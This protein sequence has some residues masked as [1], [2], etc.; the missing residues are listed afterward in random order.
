[1]LVRS[2]SGT[3]VARR[4]EMLGKYIPTESSKQAKDINSSSGEVTH[5]PHD[6]EASPVTSATISVCGIVRM[7]FDSMEKK[8]LPI[9][10]DAM[11]VA[12][13]IPRG[14]R[15]PVDSIAGVQR[16]VN[17]NIEASNRLWMMP[18]QR[19]FEPS[20]L[21]MSSNWARRPVWTRSSG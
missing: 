12:K 1:M 6:N 7:K 2:C 13:M 15:S 9:I 18:T 10:R 11:R 16:Q 17:V 8:T 3:M 5:I 19:S 4:V 20:T 21:S 14:S